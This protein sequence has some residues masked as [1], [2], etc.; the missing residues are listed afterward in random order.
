MLL[1]ARELVRV[2]ALQSGQADELEQLVDAPTASIGPGEAEA[3]VGADG[4]VGEE[5]ALLRDVAESPTLGRFVGAAVVD[6][7]PADADLALVDAV[8][9][10]HQPQQRRLAAAR[11]SEHGRERVAGHGEVDTAQHGLGA[12][13]LV[14]ADELEVAHAATTTV[15]ARRS[16]QRLMR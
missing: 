15:D 12:V 3:D 16:N 11:G 5:R 4:E 6:R 2:P 9:S 1:A 8:E 13:A 14:H 10:G 7:A